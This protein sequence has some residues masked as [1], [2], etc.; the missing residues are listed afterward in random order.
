MAGNHPRVVA[1]GRV[2]APPSIAV[3]LT[4]TPL[5]VG[6]RSRFK[7]TFRKRGFQKSLLISEHNVRV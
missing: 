1:K 4:P 3:L 2:I 5:I 7:T 6:N